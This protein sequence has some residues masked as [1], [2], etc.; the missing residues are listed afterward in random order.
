MPR[1]RRMSREQEY[2]NQ[3]R[4]ERFSNPQG[5]YS[6]YR[7]DQEQISY[8]RPLESD[9]SRRSFSGY[10]D[11]DEQDFR[12]HY[13]RSYDETRRPHSDRDLGH[14]Y[15]PAGNE[16]SYRSPNF[17]GRGPK[18][19]KRS[20]ERIMETVSEQLT[21]DPH[22][23]AS[24]IEVQ[25]RDG[26][27]TLSGHVDSR[28]SKRHAEDIIEHLPGVIDVHN[29]IEIDQSFFERIKEKAQELMGSEPDSSTH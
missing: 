20:D 23:D 11:E 16:P 12:T 4:R 6:R 3:S 18:G 29:R 15:S 2:R 9:F 7:P 14:D 25:V 21:H 24:E 28:R 17:T 8:G 26:I 19:Y 22:V 10:E 1:H 27:V 5:I 13:N